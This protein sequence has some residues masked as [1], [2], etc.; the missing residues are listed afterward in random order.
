ME[1]LIKTFYD[2]QYLFLRNIAEEIVE[3]TGIIIGLVLSI[4]ELEKPM[5][6]F[7]LKCLSTILKKYSSQNDPSYCFYK[8]YSF[9]KRLLDSDRKIDKIFDQYIQVSKLLPDIPE[10]M[11]L[12]PQV[13]RFFCQNFNCLIVSYSTS[14]KF[15]DILMIG[16]INRSIFDPLPS[17]LNS[18]I[19]ENVSKV[20]TDSSENFESF[21]TGYKKLG[22]FIIN[23]SK[24]DIS[25]LIN[26]LYFIT[27]ELINNS[28]EE[29]ISFVS[30]NLQVLSRFMPETNLQQIKILLSKSLN[31]NPNPQPTPTQE[32]QKI[33]VSKLENPYHVPKT[34]SIQS[35]SP[36]TQ[37]NEIQLG[38]K[39]KPDQQISH[40]D[41]S[42][43]IEEF[44]QNLKSNFQFIGNLDATYILKLLSEVNMNIEHS[45]KTIYKVCL[46]QIKLAEDHEIDFWV[47]FIE[48]LK[49]IID[50]QYHDDLILSLSQMQTSKIIPARGTHGNRRRPASRRI[51]AS[52][53]SRIKEIM[54]SR[55]NPYK[56]P[57]PLTE[58]KPQKFRESNPVTST[59]INPE[60]VHELCLG[61]Y[62]KDLDP[63][64][65]F[66]MYSYVEYYDLLSSYLGNL[67]AVCSSNK[68]IELKH[69]VFLDIKSKIKENSP[70][71]TLSY[72][73]L[74]YLEV[75]IPNTITDV[76]L[77]D[78]LSPNIDN[79]IKSCIDLN[80]TY[81][82]T[83]NILYRNK[84]PI[85]RFVINNELEYL[86]YSLIKKYTSIHPKLKDLIYAI[87]IWKISQKLTKQ[88]FPTDLQLI[89]IL[90]VSFQ[91]S[92]PPL[93]PRLQ[94]EYHDPMLISNL[95]TLFE[96]NPDFK[97][98]DDTNLGTLL[99]SFLSTLKTFTMSPC[100]LDPKDGLVHSIQ[101]ENL[102]LPVLGPFDRQLLY[103]S[104]SFSQSSQ[105]FL[106]SLNNTLENLESRSD[107]S[108]I[109]FFND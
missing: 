32:S 71:A 53:I 80:M 46:D 56:N 10:K 5:I 59:E 1:A 52:E 102:F 49:G 85:F 109:F 63:D 16:W 37:P 19:V 28:N 11:N 39:L 35:E 68:E 64:K 45:L 105:K 106:E 18:I 107:F 81:D 103:S 90:I 99:Q 50:D 38:S 42:S 31:Q 12:K 73:G 6:P 67:I 26:F 95:D 36:R 62:S 22:Q 72:V 40:P 87:T 77:V 70:S 65:A 66:S 2:N 33:A 44:I 76:S 4:T 79:L 24:P 89:L 83:S 104:Q 93:L 100:L 94:L 61:G 15:C 13:Y 78:Y 96:T 41:L 54:D 98:N 23:Y 30:R 25:S 34:M 17:I 60:K 86:N 27:T 47:N 69:E 7:Y 101:E 21:L 58:F 74:H 43:S 3:P 57:E 75:Y 8:F 108:K 88:D 97:A 48:G 82:E 14:L 92:E 9:A 51:V 84:K 91:V 20:Q 55:E 29:F